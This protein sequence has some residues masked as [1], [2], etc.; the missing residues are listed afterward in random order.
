MDESQGLP[1]W[2]KFATDYRPVI[3][4]VGE[5]VGIVV[6]TKVTLSE[7]PS[8]LAS[9]RVVRRLDTEG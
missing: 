3:R 7:I 2:P 4:D 8:T 5:V 6:A 9:T 1:L